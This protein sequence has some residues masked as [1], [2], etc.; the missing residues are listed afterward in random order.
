MV[1]AGIGIFNEVFSLSEE[2]FEF[3]N[4]VEDG[5]LVKSGDVLTEMSGNLGDILTA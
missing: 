4:S 1:V 2:E 3:T 5:E